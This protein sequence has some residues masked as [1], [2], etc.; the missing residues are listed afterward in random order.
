MHYLL[1]YD[2]SDD[3]L[4]GGDFRMEII[5]FLLSLDKNIHLESSVKSTIYINSQAFKRTYE[6]NKHIKDKFSDFSFV[7][8]RINYF[9]DDEDKPVIYE[10]ADKELSDS[11]TVLFKQV[12]LKLGK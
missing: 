11:F 8:A 7:L 9:K 12:K 2:K 5:E 1:A 3:G 10:K 4:E 6:L